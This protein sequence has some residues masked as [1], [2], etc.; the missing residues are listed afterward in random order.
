MGFSRIAGM[1]FA[2]TIGFVF[3]CQNETDD[4]TILV[5]AAASLGDALREVGEAFSE[6]SGVGVAFNFAGSQTLA[7]QIGASGRGD[8]F[9]SADERWMDFIGERGLWEEGTSVD[10]LSNRLA[11]VCAA[12]A[13]FQVDR[14]DELCQLDFAYLCIGDPDSVPAG[15]YVRK[16][17]E[18]ETCDNGETLW[19]LV[20]NRVSPTPDVR[21][22]LAQTLGRLDSIGIVYRTDYLSSGDRAKLL[23][24]SP[25]ADVRYPMALLKG[26]S[27]G[28]GGAAFY[29]FVQ[30]ERAMAIFEAHG[31]ERVEQ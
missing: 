19:S 13:D 24:E 4:D 31:F 3:G 1:L 8:V 30:S 18:E 23:L 15:R 5:F 6:E 16:W 11:I 2:L 22:A 26:R 12:G 29:R 9:I 14:I 27:K 21:A 28:G 17:L 25:Q 7:Q 10:L 20:R